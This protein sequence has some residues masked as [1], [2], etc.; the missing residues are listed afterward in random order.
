MPPEATMLPPTKAPP[1]ICSSTPLR[2]PPE[3]LTSPVAT[4]LP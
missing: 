2:L 1:L 4:M 3:A